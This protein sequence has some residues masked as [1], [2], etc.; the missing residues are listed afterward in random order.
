[1]RNTIFG[2]LL[3]ALGAYICVRREWV[4]E[5]LQRFYS[6]YP[7]VRLAGEE[8]QKSRGGF[9][10]AVGLVFAGIGVFGIVEEWIF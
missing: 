9:I 3:I 7:L 10:V 8:Q 5:K 2:L 1:M 6:N 4:A